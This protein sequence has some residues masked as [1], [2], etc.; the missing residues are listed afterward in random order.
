MAR[1]SQFQ[2]SA[3]IDEGCQVMD[4]LYL[5]FHG[6]GPPP[7]H[8][9]HDEQPYWMPEQHF[10]DFIASVSE[11]AASED[12]RI[13]PT[14]DDGNY[15]DIAIAAPILA[16]NDLHGIFFPCA[17]RM[18]RESYLAGDN[19][20]ALAAAGF[21]I[22]SHGIDHVP[23]KGL[24]PEALANELSGSKLA[25]EEVLGRQIASAAIPFGSYDAQVLRTLRENG[26]CI[27]Y[28]SDPGACREG[29][30]FRP[31]WSYRSDRV[32]DIREMVRRSRSLA[33]KM[34]L[35]TKRIVKSIR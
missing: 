6:I 33:H 29:A 5:A 12:I 23:W 34:V 13:V 35:R 20:R 3:G 9:P 24:S 31:R 19:I 26:Y 27:V 17:G 22:G 8:V 28:S 30:R 7:K 2:R 21:E 14:F 10:R 32:F 15:S 11:A 18:G 16:D 4:T 25:L 1:E